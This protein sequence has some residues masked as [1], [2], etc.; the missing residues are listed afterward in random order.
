MKGGRRRRAAN[1][2][3]DALD[4]IESDL[5][6]RAVVKL[7]RACRGVVRHRGSFFESAAVLEVGGD[8][9][10]A[11][12]VI[13]DLC[14]DTGRSRAAA[15]HRVGVRLWEGGCRQT[16]NRETSW[17]GKGCQGPGGNGGGG[18]GGCSGTFFA[19]SWNS[20]GNCGDNRRS[21]PDLSLN[22]GS[23]Q[24]VY[25]GRS[26]QG[27]GGG[28]S[29]AAP[30]LAGFFAQANSYLAVIGLAGQ[31]C[32]PK[33]NLICGP[34]GQ[35]GAPLYAAPG[36]APHNPYYDVNDGS[37][38]GGGPGLGYCTT[39][40]YDKATGWGS[41]NMLQLAWAI[42]WFY[43]A[44]GSTPP[45]ITF[46]GPPV[47]NWYATDQTVSFSIGGATMGV[48]GFT[49]RWDS[50][51]GDPTAHATPGS[52]DPFWDGPAVPL[53][54]SGSLDLAS[55][56]QGCHTAYVRAWDN[57]GVGALATYGPVCLGAPPNCSINFFCPFPA[58]TPPSYLIQCAA[59][60]SFFQDFI[61]GP[62]TFLLTGT[63]D[64]GQATSVPDATSIAACFPNTNNCT[65]FG[66]YVSPSDWCGPPP[67]PP[68][69]QLL[70]GLRK[71]RRHLL[72]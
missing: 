21:I 58:Y 62:N 44:Q 4:L 2:D 32:G 31:I 67:P 51:P 24:A 22:A 14:L 11:K 34:I 39:A 43:D 13:A 29:I 7:R 19:P 57:D 70:P 16:F 65:G 52:G 18:G 38:N 50:D 72:N 23:H 47:S 27:L 68:P 53:G 9:G 28:T 42:N 20:V 71:D 48:A 59:T 5:V 66:I 3:G 64:T 25:Y 33:H 8:P 37:C 49:A 69:A 26:W 41:A 45:A 15:D 30:E 55:A 1:S 35:P 17:T 61:A 36:S 56:G 40:G 12:R 54:A 10:R 60:V 63:Q 6:A 46:Q